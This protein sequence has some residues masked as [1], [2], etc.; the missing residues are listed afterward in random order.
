[1]SLQT[2]LLELSQITI[3]W[4]N[5]YYK[6]ADSK[7]FL[8]VLDKWTRFRLR[9]CIGKVWKT[10]KR[11]IRELIKLGMDKWKTYLNGNTRKGMPNGTY[12]G[13]RGRKM[14]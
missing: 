3:S 1:M 10:P 12:S 4:C 8:R 5:Y 11:R 9:M 6:L 7:S 13:V 2:P 14:K